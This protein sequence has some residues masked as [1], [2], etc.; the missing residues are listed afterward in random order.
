MV[1]APITELDSDIIQKDWSPNLIFAYKSGKAA[2][3]QEVAL[4]R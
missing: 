4:L 2:S 1:T 3:S